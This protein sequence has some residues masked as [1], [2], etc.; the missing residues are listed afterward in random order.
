MSPTPG[1]FLSG[2]RSACDP[3][4]DKSRFVAYIPFMPQIQECHLCHK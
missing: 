2:N 4:M 1:I 3:F